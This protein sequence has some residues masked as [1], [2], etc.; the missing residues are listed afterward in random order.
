LILGTLT[1][2]TSKPSSTPTTTSTSRLRN[3]QSFGK[4]LATITPQFA[5]PP[6]RYAG[7][8]GQLRS[9]KL[10]TNSKKSVPPSPS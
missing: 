7:Y 8:P 2:P 6:T 5:L 3:T 1:V 4:R 9:P 10:S